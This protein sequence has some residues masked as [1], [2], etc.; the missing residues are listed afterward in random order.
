MRSSRVRLTVR[1]M[2]ITVA[3]VAVVLAVERFLY[4]TAARARR[5]CCRWGLQLGRCS[6]CLAFFQHRLAFRC[7]NRFQDHSR[8][9]P[10]DGSQTGPETTKRGQ[11]TRDETDRI[12][13]VTVS[14][15]G[16]L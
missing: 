3:A 6:D 16:S 9:H 4:R 11:L 12:N 5:L 15:G 2:M 8:L 14:V 13:M 1:T 10:A 7:V